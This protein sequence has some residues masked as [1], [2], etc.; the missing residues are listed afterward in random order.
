MICNF[1]PSSRSIGQVSDSLPA[2]SSRESINLY[3]FLN[4]C[5]GPVEGS[6]T[7]KDKAGLVLYSSESIR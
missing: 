4:R 5:Y 2:P 3:I 1:V 6:V 7:H